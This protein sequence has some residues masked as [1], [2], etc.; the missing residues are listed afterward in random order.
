MNEQQALCIKTEKDYESLNYY[1]SEGWH[2][3][4]T[5]AHHISMKSCRDSMDTPHS[6]SNT[7]IAPI[8]VIIER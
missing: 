7:V 8:L 1:L 6:S 5:T 4:H 2:V 3:V